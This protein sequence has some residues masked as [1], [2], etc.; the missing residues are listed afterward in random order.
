M[1]AYSCGLGVPSICMSSCR[2]VPRLWETCPHVIY[3]L[4]IDIAPCVYNP[5]PRRPRS[6]HLLNR[7]L[8]RFLAPD[9]HCGKDAYFCHS[10]LPC[11]RSCSGENDSVKRIKYIFAVHTPKFVRH[12]RHRSQVKKPIVSLLIKPDVASSIS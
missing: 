4:S 6:P 1:G 12:Y 2:T 3:S 7:K 5:S 8:I 10:T 11:R 9:Q